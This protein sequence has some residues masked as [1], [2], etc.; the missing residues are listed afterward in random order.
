MS[1]PRDTGRVDAK[2]TGG[3]LESAEAS[4]FYSLHGPPRDTG[5]VDAKRTGG[6]PKIRRPCLRKGEG[7]YT[8]SPCG[9]SETLLPGSK[10]ERGRGPHRFPSP[11]CR[12]GGFR[13]T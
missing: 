3:V 12:R 11:A 13:C 2:R 7:C 10:Q 4:N 9:K 1:P 5:R 8:A 6:V